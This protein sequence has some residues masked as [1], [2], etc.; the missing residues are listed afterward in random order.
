MTNRERALALPENNIGQKRYQ[1]YKN[2]FGHINKA[3]ENSYYL[4]AI[5]LIESLI[6]DR[7][8]SRLSHLSQEDFSFKTLGQLI[9]KNNQIETDEELKQLVAT[10]LDK[11]RENRNNALHEMAKL[12]KDEQTTWDER[13]QG[14]ADIAK[15]GYEILREINKI[16]QSLRRKGQ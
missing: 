10:K 8:E 16:S 11:W 7:L 3:I 4:E 2:A 13:M 9:K 1:I 6:T 14:L 15:N 12:E 5:T